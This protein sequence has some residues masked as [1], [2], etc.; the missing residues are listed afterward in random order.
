MTDATATRPIS[1]PPR[2][3]RAMLLL[4]IVGMLLLGLVLGLVLRT[5]PAEP[6]VAAQLA[7]PSPGV[8]LVGAGDIADCTDD[9]DSATA[10]LLDEIPGTVF[11]L[12][13][14]AYERG[15][16]RE[17]ADCYAPTWGRHRARTHPVPGNHEYATP[18]ASGYFGY[19]GPAAGPP[20]RG[21]YAYDLG[22]WRLYA[23]NSNCASIGGCGASSEQYRWLIGD[24]Q[25]HPSTC[26]AAFWH[27][28]RF[29]SGRHGNYPRMQAIWSALYAAGAELVVVGHDHDYERIGPV[30]G[31]GQPAPE[32]GMR[33]IVVG[34]GGKA[35]RSFGDSVL[36][37]SQVR[38]DTTFGVLKL[39]LR[40]AS[41]EW[42]FV[43]VPGSAFT[44]SGS[45]P[46]HAAPP[47]ARPPSPATTSS[48]A[49]TP[50]PDGPAT[51]ATSAAS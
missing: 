22:G 50:S 15:T 8:V 10:A 35:L 28:P 27:H 2:R 47:G 3:L 33:Q 29:S 38:N 7:V 45:S 12:G 51:T 9:G 31:K 26:V 48:P 24:L 32:H 11:T 36:A 1:R 14:N 18:D 49:T 30:D 4:A 25:A 16:A 34:T 5:R 6:S 46:C 40:Q 19:F 42:R 13:D 44:D 41:Y 43:P 17:Y 21:Y 20:Q 39:T 23:L 37:I